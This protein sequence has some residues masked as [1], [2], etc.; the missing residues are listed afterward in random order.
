MRGDVGNRGGRTAR[1]VWRDRRSRSESIMSEEKE[2]EDEQERY[3]QS[4]IKEAAG[5]E[6]VIVG[7]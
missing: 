6:R 5:R 2:R 1:D 3:R 7:L 4:M